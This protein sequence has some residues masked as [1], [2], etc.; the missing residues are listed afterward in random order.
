MTENR[1][2]LPFLIPFMAKVS[3]AKIFGEIGIYGKPIRICG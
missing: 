1:A 2:P 3:T